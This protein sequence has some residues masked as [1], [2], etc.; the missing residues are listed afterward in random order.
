MGQLVQ[1][2][3]VIHYHGLPM[4]PEAAAATIMRN[5]HA[6]VS[7]AHPAQ[8]AL[9]AEVCST[10]ALDNGAFSAWRSGRAVEWSQYYGWVAAWRV[11][12]CDFAVIPDVIDGD[13]E[14]NDALIAEWPHGTFGVPVWHLHE[15]IARLRRLAEVW[16]RVALGSSGDFAQIGSR[17]WW[18]RMTDAFDAICDNGFPITRVHGLRMLDPEVT[19]AFPFASADS[20]NVA[21]NIGIDSAWRGTYTPISKAARGVVMADRIEATHSPAVYRRPQITAQ[22]FKD[23]P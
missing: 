7:F 11:P 23:T 8:V 6:F 2:S 14:A 20:T 10:F 17:Q 3:C 4:T 1:D 22:L 13:E 9:A 19:A 5:R 15:S 18:A 12:A 21:R 16:P